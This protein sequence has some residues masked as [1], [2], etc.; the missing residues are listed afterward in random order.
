MYSGNYRWSYAPFFI[1]DLNEYRRKMAAATRIQA[2][3][4]GRMARRATNQLRYAPPGVHA[5]LAAGGPGYQR[6]ARNFRTLSLR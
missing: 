6:M 3:Y 5:H 1:W 2:A 4:R